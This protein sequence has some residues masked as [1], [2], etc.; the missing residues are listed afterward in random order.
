MI[1]LPEGFDAAAL[2]SELLQ[3]AAPFAGIALLI[4]C[5]FLINRMLKKAPQ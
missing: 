1:Q 5:G 2:F 3:L 4:A